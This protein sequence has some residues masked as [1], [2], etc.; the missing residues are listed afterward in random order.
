MRCVYSQFNRYLFQHHNVSSQSQPI[1]NGDVQTS[2]VA[3]I[4][5]PVTPPVI[6]EP[7]VRPP[8]PQVIVSY[9]FYYKRFIVLIDVGFEKLFGKI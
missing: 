4:Y 7:P 6:V 1:E 8:L 3:V 5:S 2:D 9:L